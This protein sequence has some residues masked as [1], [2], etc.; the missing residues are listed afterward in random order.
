M[1]TRQIR[2]GF[3]T[4]FLVN[5]D[6]DRETLVYASAGHPPALVKFADASKGS[7][8]LECGGGI[9]LGIEPDHEWAS[10]TMQFGRQDL[11]VLYTD[12]AIEAESPAGEQFGVGGLRQ[13]IENSRSRDPRALLAE[14]LASLDRHSANAP[15]ADD[16][17]IVV[18][19]PDL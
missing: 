19:Q 10:E 15:G 16:C 17:T 4:V 13:V 8:L 9:P 11:L 7:R 1:F 6:A 5:Y 18:V 14:I 12:G 2:G 3:T